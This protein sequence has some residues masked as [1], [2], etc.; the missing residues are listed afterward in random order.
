MPRAHQTTRTLGVSAILSLALAACAAE[1]PE[2]HFACASAADCPEG[3]ACWSDGLCY[4][5]EEL[6]TTDGG[7]SD[8]NI[9]RDASI[10]DAGVRDAQPA[11]DAG[12]LDANLDAGVATDASP[13]ADATPPADASVNPDGSVSPDAGPP[14]CT[15]TGAPSTFTLGV[16]E[17]TMSPCPSGFGGGETRLFGALDPGP[18]C[19]GTCACQPRP[20]SCLGELFIYSTENQCVSDTA[21]VGGQPYGPLV[22]SQCT[23]EPVADGFP[24]GFRL[25]N[26]TVDQGCIASGSAAPSPYQ[27]MNATKFCAASLGTGGCDA[28]E[29]CVENAAVD[30]TCVI[31][32]GGAACP[33]PYTNR[34]TEWFTGL[35]DTRSCG[36]CQCAV[37]GGSCEFAQVAIGSDW[38]CTDQAYL[39]LQNPKSCGSSYSPPARV[40]GSASPPTCTPSSPQVGS[41]QATGQ[42]TLCC[43]P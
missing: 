19:V 27:W 30:A 26:W 4:S 17:D 14:G 2:G 8:A 43:R 39:S 29:S 1:I 37:S 25:G 38:S 36:A 22:T 34:I 35:S 6:T 28:S 11:G 15:C 42:Q 31:T 16:L 23:P 20:T 12:R 7:A 18:G 40:L 10:S 33:A 32:S 13:G 21:L 41:I 5:T 3:W 9:P 24:G